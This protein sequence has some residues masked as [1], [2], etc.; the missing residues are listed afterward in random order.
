MS[1][2]TEESDCLIS[3]QIYHKQTRRCYEPL[4]EGPC[5]QGEWLVLA[6]SSSGID[7]Q[8]SHIII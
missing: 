5:K 6:S 7:I 1:Q 8:Y 2:H 4:A 3:N